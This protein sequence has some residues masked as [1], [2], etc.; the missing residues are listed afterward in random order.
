VLYGS[1]ASLGHSFPVYLRFKGGKGVATGAGMLLGIA[2]IT[3]AIGFVCWVLCMVLSR[4]VSLSSIVAAIAVMVSVW[5]LDSGMVINTV[6]TI[7]AL[8]V[9][10]LH[11]ANIRRLLSGTENRFGKRKE[12]D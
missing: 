1:C 10:W 11:R 3:V 6:L 9:I 8:L 5:V 2:P 12:A 7:L 4:I